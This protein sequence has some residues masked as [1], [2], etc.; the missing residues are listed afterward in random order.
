MRKFYDLLSSEP[1][2]IERGFLEFNSLSDDI[3]NL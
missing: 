3:E 2:S 1:F